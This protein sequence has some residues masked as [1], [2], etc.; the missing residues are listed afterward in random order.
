MK[1]VF[2]MNTKNPRI[3]PRKIRT[4]KLLRNAFAELLQ[5]MDIEKITVNRLADRAPLIVLLFIYTI[6]TFLT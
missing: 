3:D 4:P 1:G 6:V 5:E 2:N